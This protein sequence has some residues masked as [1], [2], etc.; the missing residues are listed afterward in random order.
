MDPL[1]RCSSDIRCHPSH[2]HRHTQVQ[3]DSAATC[4]GLLEVY[5]L[6]SLEAET[7]TSNLLTLR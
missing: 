3:E 5:P 7:K 2:I 4:T 6:T 1:C